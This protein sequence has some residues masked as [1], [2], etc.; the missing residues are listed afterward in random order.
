[1]GTGQDFVLHLKTGNTD[2]AALPA[3]TH[4]AHIH[5]PQTARCAVARSSSPTGKEAEVIMSYFYIP[6]HGTE[7]WSSIPGDSGYSGERKEAALPL[8][9]LCSNLPSAVGTLNCPSLPLLLDLENSL[10]RITKFL[11]SIFFLQYRLCF[12]IFLFVQL[13]FFCLF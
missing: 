11:Q 1:M 4:P 2:S 12:Q 5:T 9:E 3:W 8:W 10:G 6:Q 13:L 7:W